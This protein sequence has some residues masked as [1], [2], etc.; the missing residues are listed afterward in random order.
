MKKTGS[1][2]KQS[3]KFE[4]KNVLC[5]MKHLSGLVRLRTFVKLHFYRVQDRGEIP[6][7]SWVNC[8]KLLKL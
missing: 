5:W 7:L 6:L 4:E 1:G 3:V 8:F 2:L